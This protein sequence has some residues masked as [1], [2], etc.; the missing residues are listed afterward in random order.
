MP[1]AAKYSAVAQL[2][3]GR[4]LDIRALNQNDRAAFEEA[5]GRMSPG[6]LYR[7]FFSVKRS[8]TSQEVGYSLSVD[9]VNEIAVVAIV[10]EGD[11]SGMVG[12]GRY[13][14]TRPRRAELAFAVIDEYQ[15]Q[16]IGKALM[17]HLVA[18][19][20]ES[21]LDELFAEVL[22]DNVAMLKVFETSECK[23]K[24]QRTPDVV[25]ITIDLGSNLATRKA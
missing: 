21:G 11:R 3:D 16:G 13:F 5:I 10:E 22:P 24:L 20:R 9:F 1:D 25:K 15:G 18:I 2:P 7:R 4:R 6:S 12:L 17:R 19:A 8:F 14:I 23:V